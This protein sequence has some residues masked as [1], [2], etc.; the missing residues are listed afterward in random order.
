MHG[1]VYSSLDGHPK[2]GRSTTR[3]EDVVAM[4]LGPG[5]K[6]LTVMLAHGVLDGWDLTSGDFLGHADARA[7]ACK[8]IKKYQKYNYQ[9]TSKIKSYSVLV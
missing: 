3:Y 9:K 4:Q 2:R 8:Q 1:S 6:T 5:G 7:H